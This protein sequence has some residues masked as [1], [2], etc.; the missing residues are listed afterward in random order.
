V[1]EGSTPVVAFGDPAAAEVAT[2]GINPSASEFMNNGALLTDGQRR[3]A[4]LASLGADGLDVLTDDQV[5]AVVADCATYFHRRPYRRW[6]DPLDRLLK[7]A[8]DVSYYDES[9]CHLDLVQW[10]TDPIW[11]RI[12]DREVR[13][14]LLDDGVEYLRAQLTHEN[15]RTIL[16]NGRA[17]LDQVTAVGLADLQVVGTLPVGKASCRLYT[18]DG[19]GVRWYGWSTNLQSS[20]GVS[21]RF[22]EE[23]AAWIRT[24]EAAAAALTPDELRGP[25]LLDADGYLRADLAIEGKTELARV[26]SRWLR[27]STAMTVGNVGRFGGRPWLRITVG[28][29][30]VVVNAD[31]KRAAVEQFVR[32]SNNDPER[33]WQVNENRRGR[34]NKVTPNADGPPLPGWYAYLSSPWTEQATL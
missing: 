13:Q 5:T 34:I 29:H 26:L 20:F 30:E 31:T 14:T 4:T 1:V 8:L 12:P 17:V 21:A 16:L 23:L 32:D 19:G 10:A 27:E 33:D 24:T 3:L 7:A 28:A 9:A 6:F 15:V 11:G 25:E 2:L 22:K 18:G